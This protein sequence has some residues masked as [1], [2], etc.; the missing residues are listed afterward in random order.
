M[1]LQGRRICNTKIIA[2]D[3]GTGAVK[4]PLKPG[5]FENGHYTGVTE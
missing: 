4:E 3:T 5:G 2:G 1:Q